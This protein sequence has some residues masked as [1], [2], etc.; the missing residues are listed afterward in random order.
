MEGALIAKFGADIQ[1]FKKKMDEVHGIT[2]NFT[3]VIDDLGPQLAAAFSIGAITAF[4][5]ASLQAAGDA[6][7]GEN[8]LLVALRGRQDI[9]QR[10]IQQA[11]D[12]QGRT[13]FEDDAIVKAQAFLA[14]LGR[15]ETQI[16]RVIEAA[17]QLSS[18]TGVDLNVAVES[19][20]KTYEGL[21]KGLKSIDP[22]MQGF[23]K[24][25]LEHGDA[26]EAVIKKYQGF[27]EQLTDTG[28]GPLKQFEKQ[29]GEIQEDLGRWAL[30]TVNSGLKETSS[31]IKGLT[32]DDINP[33]L[34]YFAAV[35]APFTGGLSL[36]FIQGVQSAKDLR[37]STIPV[38]PDAANL[39]PAGFNP[40]G[41]SYKPAISNSGPSYRDRGGFRQMSLPKI[42]DI[43]GGEG[44]D[45]QEMIKN[46]DDALQELGDHM[47][48]GSIAAGLDALHAQ[49]QQQADD[50]E[51]QKAQYQA[52]GTLLGDQVTMAIAGQ[53]SFA[54][55]FS[56]ATRSILGDLAARA[57]A[58][59]IVQAF[60]KYGWNPLLAASVAGVSFG[61]I[62]G[63]FSRLGASTPTASVVSSGMS[64]TG[65]NTGP[66]VQSIQVYGTIKGTD[67]YL[68]GQNFA[69]QG[70]YLRPG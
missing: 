69:Q 68:L 26:V 34:R 47:Q 4:G 52:Y 58:N 18:A 8:K 25:Q 21:D 10:L 70:T 32:N 3:K 44:K 16:K 55:A 35:S 39:S 41:Y 28:T 31:I 66:N 48:N 30:P 19:L 43:W 54:Q 2:A 61:I 51:K 42:S 57:A 67:L 9:Q 14:A 17:V 36:K 1:D 23:T 13:L 50:L 62:K 29:L 15:N 53:E 5:K 11:S 65:G 7:D 12:L 46:V 45:P 37:N 59:A 64:S 63:L 33:W 40:A 56:N 22:S 38:G 24:T 6:V 20:N 60:E 49:W 27:A